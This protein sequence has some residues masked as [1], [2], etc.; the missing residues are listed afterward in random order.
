[1]LS[2]SWPFAWWGMDLLGPFPTA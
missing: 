1:M 2:S